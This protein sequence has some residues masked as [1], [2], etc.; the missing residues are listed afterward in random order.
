M[1]SRRS[2][3]EA[4]Q[5][6]G[7]AHVGQ[8]LLGKSGPLVTINKWTK[9][10]E[11]TK[12]L[13]ENSVLSLPVLDEE[14]QYYGCLS[15]NDILRHVF[16]GI[17]VEDAEWTEHMSKFTP[18]KLAAIGAAF[19]TQTV[20]KL[21]HDA[22]LWLLSADNSSS[23]LDAVLESFH[24]QDAHVHHR[25]FIC[26]PAREQPSNTQSNTTVVN[27]RPGSERI[28]ASGWKVTNVI[29]HTDVVKLLAA[30]R[31]VMTEAITK[32]VDELELDA[33]AVFCVP[34]SMTALE[35]F[36]YMF[37]DHKSSLGLTDAAGKLIGN[38]SVS[39]LRGLIGAEF[40]LLLLSAAEYKLALA[41]KGTSKADALAGKRLPDAVAALQTQCPVVAVKPETTFMQVLDLLVEKHLHRVYVVDDSGV[42]I[43]IIT[44][45]DILRAVTKPPV[46]TPPPRMVSAEDMESDD[47]DDD[48]DDDEPMTN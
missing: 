11:A 2:F 43:S 27:I 21:Q 34:A 12:L 15:V 36:G 48:D 42:A 47:D 10:A 31:Q 7:Q 24:I 32:T 23:V 33:G 3:E 39:D 14:T 29:S 38:L 9:V 1:P 45:T 37:R 20:D 4:R 46:V 13:A 22:D 16:T 35:A 40:P 19:D 17:Q 30:N 44:L 26:T 28:A 41:S 5:F 8:T 18:D 6:L 25:L